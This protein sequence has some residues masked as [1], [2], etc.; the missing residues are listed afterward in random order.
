MALSDF[1]V[2]TVVIDLS[3]VTRH[4]LALMLG[5]PLEQNADPRSSV[6]RY[7][8]VSNAWDW[9]IETSDAVGDGDGNLVGFVTTYVLPIEDQVFV[10]GHSMGPLPDPIVR[11]ISDPSS[12]DRA[13]RLVAE[14]LPNLWWGLRD[15]A[16]MPD[17]HGLI[18]VRT[19][20][21][22]WLFGGLLRSRSTTS[23]DVDPEAVNAIRERALLIFG[24]ALSFPG[25]LPGILDVLPPDSR[26][27]QW[28][29]AASIFNNLATIV[30]GVSRIMR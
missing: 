25:N 8:G 11:L 23:V 10:V 28:E 1:L 14:H 18:R 21:N 5:G 15:G 4:P 12:G 26:G 20:G 19:N 16:G 13:A 9:C 17:G 30:D 6:D 7:G 29:Q 24:E 3:T 27:Q 22:H 2:D